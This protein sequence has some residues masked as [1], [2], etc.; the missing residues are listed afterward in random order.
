[1]A[2]ILEPDAAGRGR[3]FISECLDCRKAKTAPPKRAGLLQQR[4]RGGD[5]EVLSIDV[6]GPLPVSGRDKNRYI[7]VMIDPFSL[8]LTLSVLKTK[9]ATSIVEAFIDDII[10]HGFLPSKIILSDNGSAFQIGL[11]QAFIRQL[12]ETFKMGATRIARTH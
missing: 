5:L 1:M 11:F 10:L 9:K 4:Y 3:D 6:F 7:L 2:A 8:Y 12:R